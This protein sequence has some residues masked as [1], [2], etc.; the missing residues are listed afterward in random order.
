RTD[1]PLATRANASCAELPLPRQCAPCGELLAGTYLIDR[2]STSNTSV[3]AGAPGRLG[4]S[5]YARLPGIQKRALSPATIS[6]NPSVHPLMT[7]FSGND[8][9]CPRATEL[10]N[11]LPSVVQPA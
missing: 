2:S 9:G 4:V 10:S 5:P 7:P 1:G 6:C 8:V 11:I 3:P